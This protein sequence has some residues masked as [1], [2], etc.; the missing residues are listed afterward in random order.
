MGDVEGGVVKAVGRGLLVAKCNQDTATI[1]ISRSIT[2]EFGPA[3][4]SS[5]QGKLHAWRDNID[6]VLQ[7]LRSARME[8]AK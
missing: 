3:Q 7:R 5:L 2:R 6:G 8:T 4:W 1:T